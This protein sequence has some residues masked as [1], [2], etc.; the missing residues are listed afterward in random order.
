MANKVIWYQPS[1]C[2][3]HIAFPGTS[4]KPGRQVTVGKLL[5]KNGWELSHN[6]AANYHQ[7]RRAHSAPYLE[8]L[9]RT[10]QMN[11]PK[12]VLHAA[13]SPFFQWYT[14]P[15][16]GSYRAAAHAAGAVCA[17]I[18]DLIME[19]TRR[20]FC[21]VRPPGHH[22]GE[23]YGEGF[24]ILNNVA[25]GALEAL[26]RKARVAIIDFDRH[27]G[28][29]TEEIVAKA[30]DPGALFVSSYQEG[31]KYAAGPE[32]KGTRSKILRVPLPKGGRGPE[33]WNLY[34]TVVIP[35][36]LKHNP[37]FILISAGFDL[38]A[39]DALKPSVRLN[40][41]DYALLTLLITQAA[42]E[43]GAG[44]VSVL[45]GGY[46]LSSLSECVEAH[47]RVLGE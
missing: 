30:N 37:D 5:E 13:V 43:L 17:G 12:G 46:T 38:H 47:V 19:R 9:A 35:A 42:D 14:A 20:V 22:A 41:T 44:I 6:P 45:E 40:T 28:N 2:Q 10:V 39:D 4:E 25:I 31:C 1:E 33:V 36:L 7:L 27:H 32:P 3:G 34:R 16:G 24:C 8:A 11:L 15:Y 21:A 29:G 23:S 18:N 26:G